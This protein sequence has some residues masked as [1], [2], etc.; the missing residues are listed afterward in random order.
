MTIDDN[1]III[2]PSPPPPGDEMIFGRDWLCEKAEGYAYD[3]CLDFVKYGVDLY[4]H[5]GLW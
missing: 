2:N 4:P 5:D 3:D 1:A